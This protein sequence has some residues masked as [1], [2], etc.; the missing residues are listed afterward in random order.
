MMAYPQ[1]D[2]TTPHMYM[3]IPKGFEF[4]GSKDTHCL[5][6]LATSMAVR[7]PG[8]GIERAGIQTVNSISV[9]VLQG[10]TIFMVYVDDGVLIDPDPTKISK[11]IL[12]MQSRFDIQD[13]GELSENLG[14]KVSQHSNGSIEFT[15]LQLIN[16]ILD[17]GGSSWSKST[18][19]PCKQ[20]SKTNNN[21]GV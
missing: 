9:C 6:C 19:T 13:K 3:E 2:I 21:E 11:A 7:A 1:A 4:D 15:Q 17:H 16:S 5:L 20:I 14:V 10:T 8:K 18:D 12:D